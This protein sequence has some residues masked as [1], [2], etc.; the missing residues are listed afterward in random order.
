MP[1]VREV[2]YED[3]DAVA[4]L[5]R[6]EGW[7][8]P[9]LADWHHLW[10]D[11]PAL[12]GAPVSRGWVLV[13]DGAVV[14]FVGNILQS[15]QFG[16][17][18]LR[19]ATAAAMVVAPPFR[20]TSLQLLV[21]FAKQTGVD[22]LLNTT[23]A[24]Q[25]SKIS[26]F[27][28]FTRI[29]QPAY[30][31]SFYWVLRP[32]AFAQSGLR[33]KG[34]QPSVSAVAAPLLVPAVW[35]EGMLRGRG[36]RRPGGDGPDLRVA[37]AHH[38]RLLA[39]RDAPALRWHFARRGRAH[40]PRIIAAYAGS[41]LRGYAAIVRQDASHLGL[42]RARLADLIADADDPQVLR[43]LVAGAAAEAR[44]GGA[45]MLAAVGFPAPTRRIFQESRPFE[46]RNESWP[47]LFKTADASLRDALGH[48]S[49][50]YACLYDGDGSL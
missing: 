28:K 29:P 33:K 23:A 3:L 39:V 48:E 6:A 4:R 50:W 25:V 5:Q 10:R 41:R 44:R 17:R 42:A 18:M 20:G 45:A 16:A 21:S 26:E 37:D 27:L 32:M 1:A 40:P 19:A 22:L 34:W 13:E 49:A 35:A 47:F 15:Y 36:P 31:V 12:A 46:L 43:A 11:N 38:G 7:G 9:S 24:P 8:A 14:G 30:D 2:Q